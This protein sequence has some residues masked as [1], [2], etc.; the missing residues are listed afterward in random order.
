M[1]AV[2]VIVMMPVMTQRHTAPSHTP[3]PA[4][5]AEIAR[6][7]IAHPYTVVRRMMRLPVR[8][9]V[10]ERIDAELTRRGLVD[11]EEHGE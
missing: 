9:H 2:S 8:G 7:A 3:T 4:E 11:A 5:I 6:A 10:A 1:I